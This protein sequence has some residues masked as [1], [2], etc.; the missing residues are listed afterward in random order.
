[1]KHIQCSYRDTMRD[2]SGEQLAILLPLGES[3]MPIIGG[4]DHAQ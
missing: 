3:V 1:M 4:L 2:G